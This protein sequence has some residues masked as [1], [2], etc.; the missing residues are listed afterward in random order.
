MALISLPLTLTTK[1]NVSVELSDADLK[2]LKS[3]TV[4]E[5]LNELSGDLADEVAK[6]LEDI[7]VSDEDA[8]NMI[9]IEE[10]IDT[11]FEFHEDKIG[12]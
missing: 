10:H 5:S 12:Q 1:V 8:S 6:A 3:G 7:S 2:T 9:T 11:E 4:P